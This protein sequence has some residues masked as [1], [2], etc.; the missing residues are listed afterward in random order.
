MKLADLA[1]RLQGQLIGDGGLDIVRVADLRTAGSGDI[2]FLTSAEYRPA[3]V[4]TAASAVLLKAADADVCPVAA[5]VVASPYLAYAKVAQWLDPTPVP[6]VG[7]APTSS[8]DPS[9]I[10]PAS[11]SIGPGAVIGPG[12]VLAEGV[13]IGANAV[14]AENVSIGAGTRLYPNVTVYH[15][16]IIGAGCR[17]HSGTVIG[18]DGFGYAQEQRQWVRIPQVGTVRIADEVDIGANCT[19][20]RGA[21]GDTVIEQGVKLDNLIHIAHNVQIGA[22]TAIAGCSAVAG[23]AVIGK[24]VTLAGRVG[25]L[26][27]LSVCDNVHVTATTLVTKSITEPG[28]YSSGTPFQD[29]RSWRKNAARFNQLDDLARRLRRLEKASGTGQDENDND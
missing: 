4:A 5:I 13:I 23:S 12:C 29:N 14:L 27:H 7:V 11:A 28:V 22:H 19:I 18:S 24:H 26:G 16:V 25:V 9:A 21:L 10:I 15:G 3:L 20:D 8:I 2:S 17:I 6:A 1:A